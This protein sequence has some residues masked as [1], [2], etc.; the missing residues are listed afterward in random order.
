MVCFGKERKE[1]LF[2]Y[3]VASITYADFNILRPNASHV[4]MAYYQGTCLFPFPIGRT[5]GAQSGH[6]AGRLVDPFLI[7]TIYA[8]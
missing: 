4:K 8:S 6:Y 2:Q 1:Y 5:I 7:G 3:V